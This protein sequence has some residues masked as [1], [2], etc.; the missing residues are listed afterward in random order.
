MKI[1]FF[2]R[3]ELIAKYL[4]KYHINDST[5]MAN[6]GIIF[7]T[8]PGLNVAEDILVLIGIRQ[9]PFRSRNKHSIIN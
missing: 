2:F 5:I 6:P 1:F 4:L 8:F 3:N 7:D 9:F